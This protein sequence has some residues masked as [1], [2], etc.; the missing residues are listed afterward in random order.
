ML[1]DDI[2]Q[3]I[4]EILDENGRAEFTYIARK[5]NRSE[6][7]VRNRIRRLRDRGVVRGFKVIT[8]PIN[9]GFAINAYVKFHIRP[10]YETLLKI[11]K[12]PELSE[13]NICSLESIFRV[14]SSKSTYML[15]VVSRTH[16]NLK[17][18]VEAIKSFDDSFT[19]V[20]V[21][22]KEEKIYDCRNTVR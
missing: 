10:N 4:L 20:Q 13:K 18:F 5:I 9:L 15:E 17:N 14:K 1:T 21:I 3:Q 11:D 19:D 7:T 8:D 6:G 16:E 12:F 2:D 22:I